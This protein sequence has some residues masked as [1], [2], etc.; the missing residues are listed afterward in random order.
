MNGHDLFQQS[1]LVMVLLDTT[2][3]F[4]TLNRTAERLFG[5]T[6]AE[7]IGHPFLT[8]LD[9]FSHLKGE[10]MIRRTCATGGLVDWELNHLQAEGPP[11][12]IGYTTSLLHDADG[13]SAG[14]A[15]AG[16]AG[17]RC[18]DRPRRAPGT[19]AAP[20]GNSVK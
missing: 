8:V 11:L 12:L 1:S 6:A 4:I 20:V 2:G 13:A 15:A 18:G 3:H 14:L 5:H 7:L 10:L 9:P 16:R 19:G 17:A